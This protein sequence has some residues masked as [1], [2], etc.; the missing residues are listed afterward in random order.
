[1]SVDPDVLFIDNGQFITSAGASAGLD[2]CLHLVRNDHGQA[3]AAHA[4]RLAVA[5]L[6]REGGQAQFIEHE[7]PDSSASLAP[8]L[9]WLEQ[10]LAHTLTIDQLA[11]RAATSPRTLNRRFQEQLGM[12]PVQCLLGARIRRAQ[13]LLETSSLPLEQIASAV[14]FEGA[15]SLRE[16]FR[17]T[18]GVS[19]GTYRRAF[20]AKVAG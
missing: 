20:N 16:R 7:A 8:L 1:M 17:R 19:P 15:A 9:E 12:P 10:N 3:I 2:M 4:A 11:S 14:G 6:M 5:P 18:L 13:E